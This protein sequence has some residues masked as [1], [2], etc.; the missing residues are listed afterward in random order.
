MDVHG[1]LGRGGLGRGQFVFSITINY[2]LSIIHRSPSPKNNLVKPFTDSKIL[3]TNADMII[4]PED[5]HGRGQV[6][7][8]RVQR[9]LVCGQWPWFVAALS[10]F[11]C[12]CRK[13]N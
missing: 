7:D 10:F 1:G 2:L 6:L 13:V 12:E 4:F 8:T 5:R 3:E 9:T 11:V